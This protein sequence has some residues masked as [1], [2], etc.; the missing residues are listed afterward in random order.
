MFVFTVA[1]I[2]NIGGD[3]DVFELGYQ[4]DG[5]RVVGVHPVLEPI[6]LLPGYSVSGLAFRHEKHRFVSAT[7]SLIIEIFRFS[8]R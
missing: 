1:P 6:Y 7:V 2:M 3:M 8:L 4:V 5:V